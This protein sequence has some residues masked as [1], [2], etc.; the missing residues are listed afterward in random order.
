M[1][2]ASMCVVNLLFLLGMIGVIANGRELLFG[3]TP[4]A[5]T[6]LFLPPL[7]AALT[8]LSLVLAGTAWR[9]NRWRL[10]SRLYYSLLGLL[11]LVFIGSLYYWN[12]LGTRF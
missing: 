1:A 6:V 11:G 3:L 8:I 10:R 5:R 2:A 12:L 7:S 4:L 9:R